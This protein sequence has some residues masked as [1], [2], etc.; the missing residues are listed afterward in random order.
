MKIYKYENSFFFTFFHVIF[1]IKNIVLNI[2]YYWLKTRLVFF[3]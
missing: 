2:L 1:I 3:I